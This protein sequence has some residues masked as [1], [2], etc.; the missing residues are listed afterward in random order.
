[1]TAP[2]PV[3]NPSPSHFKH[4]V[5]FC[6]NH[7]ENGVVCCAV[8]DAQ[9]MQ[10][11][12]KERCQALGI[13]GDDQVRIN[14]A[15]CLGR[16]NSGPVLVVYPDATWYTYVD[17]SDIDEIIQSHLLEGRPVQRLMVDAPALV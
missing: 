15:G 17:K 9:A 1:M 14:R 13:H 12:A 5:F 7:R 8:H 10:E 4:H 6:L 16:C 2:S 11:Y 3:P